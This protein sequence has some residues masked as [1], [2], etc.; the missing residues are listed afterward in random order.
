ML[1]VL[2]YE[3][4]IIKFNFICF[5]L[6]FLNVTMRTFKITYLAHISLWNNADKS[7]STLIDIV[8]FQ[9][10]YFEESIYVL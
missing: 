1:D 2:A 6:P 5:L 10:I 4:Y 8:P 3:K 9:D 7:F